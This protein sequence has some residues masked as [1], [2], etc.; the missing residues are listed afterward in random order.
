MFKR[1]FQRNTHT[2]DLSALE[3][4]VTFFNSHHALKAE[5]VL[6]ESNHKGALVPGPREISPN[7]GTA[8]RFDYADKDELPV[9]FKQHFVQYE[10]IHYYPVNR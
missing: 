3:G 5:K 6:K 9:L 10:D 2:E 7:C 1:L 4:I 8:L